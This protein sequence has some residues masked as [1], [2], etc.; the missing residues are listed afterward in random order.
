MQGAGNGAPLH[1]FIEYLSGPLRGCSISIAEAELHLAERSGTL[2]M[3]GDV[4]DS[5]HPS[6]L[7]RAGA[8]YE[9]VAS[10]HR[11]VWVNNEPVKT[12][13]LESG[14]L[15]ELED[16]P[17][18]RFWIQASRASPRKS[19]KEI[20]AAGVNATRRW[21]MR[22]WSHALRVVRT[23]P[24]HLLARAWRRSRVSVL[25]GLAGLIGAVSYLAL[26]SHDLEQQLAHEQ[27]RVSGLAE[28]LSKLEGQALTRNELSVLRDEF[29]KGLIDTGER[30]KVLEASSA[31]AG[32]IIA[33]ASGSVALVHGSFGFRDPST[34]RLLRFAVAQDGSPVR[35]PDGRPLMTLEGSGPPV[36]LR[37]GGTAFVAAGDGILLTNRHIA[38]PWEGEASLPAVRAL[39]LEPVMLRMRGYLPGATESF[40]IKL[41]A[42]S[43]THDLAI[44]QGDGAAR[45]AI[46]LPLSMNPPTP[47]EAAVLLGFP[48]GIR[49]LLA[50]AGDAF[51]EKLSSK[52]KVDVDQAM[53]ELARAGL[54]KPLASRGIVGQVSGEAIIYDAQTT[55]GGSGGPVFNLTGDVMAINRATLPEFGGSNIGVPARHAM[56]LMQN[57]KIGPEDRQHSAAR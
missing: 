42:T 5:P 21:W 37:F 31:A 39:G 13:V 24:L 36:E 45:E 26:Q 54:I 23:R 48:T 50:R 27:K 14:D 49:A 16:G 43:D 51:V 3:P 15:I 53:V 38:L 10:K 12:R 34:K 1:A 30:V 22:L 28:L 44:L 57:L 35:T 32:Q 4:R 47:G 18:L 8:R 41:L 52:A 19:P 2:L 17:V 20:S 25:I 7:R 29:G 46:P 9:L 40:D 55:T 56:E 11:A 6:T 33:R